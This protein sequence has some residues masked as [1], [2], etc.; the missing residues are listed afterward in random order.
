MKTFFCKNCGNNTHR[1]RECPLPIISNGI[2]CVKLDKSINLK[3][4]TE[5]LKIERYNSEHLENISKINL[6]K[7]KIKFLLIRRRHTYNFINFVRGKYEFKE[8]SLIELFK[9]MSPEEIV[10]LGTYPFKKIWEYLWRDTSWLKSYEKE[11]QDAKNKFETLLLFNEGK[12]FKYLTTELIPDYL[13]PEWGF[14]KGKR[15]YLEDNLT[16]AKR[17]FFEETTIT[18]SE[19]QVLDNVSPIEENLTVENKNYRYNYYLAVYSGKHKKF[20]VDDNH[21]V[22][23][24][25]WFTLDET[26]Q[27]LRDYNQERMK[28][29]QKIYLFLVNLIV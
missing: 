23:D 21:E 26:L 17:E 8:E 14:P 10:V 12:T 2:I 27:L 25:G 3:N 13:E 11:Y 6:F 20:K 22:G 29:I 15:E 1:Y 24:I 18:N 9:L 7:K 16:S 4:I 19:F 28:L 5:Y